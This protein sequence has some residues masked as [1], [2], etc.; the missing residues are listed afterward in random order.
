MEGR[1]DSQTRGDEPEIMML[2]GVMLS[3]DGR[4]HGVKANCQMAWMI[5]LVLLCTIMTRAQ[6]SAVCTIT[7]SMR[8][9][10]LH[11]ETFRGPRGGYKSL[12]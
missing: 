10:G 11:V 8:L 3:V 2:Q 12:C 1:S 7:D 9:I 6:V 5:F 4:E